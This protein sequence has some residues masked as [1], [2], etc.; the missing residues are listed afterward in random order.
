M[1]QKLSQT[2]PNSTQIKMIEYYPQEQKL[3]AHFYSNDAIYEY[4]GVPHEVYTILTEAESEG[5]AFHKI[6]KSK[7]YLTKRIA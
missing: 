2:F 4:S 3:V 1:S 7:G 5:S 6:V